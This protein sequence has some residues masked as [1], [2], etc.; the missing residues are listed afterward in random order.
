MGITVGTPTATGVGALMLQLG[1]PP[2]KVE[3]MT[4][5]VEFATELQMHFNRLTD[6]G[7]FNGVDVDYEVHV[8]IVSAL[9]G[10]LEVA[11]KK[12]IRADE[13]SA[14]DLVLKSS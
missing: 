1:L 5:H 7:Q 6:C 2:S 8:K 14:F 3:T 12:T 9:D 10:K 13:S 4:S 11:E